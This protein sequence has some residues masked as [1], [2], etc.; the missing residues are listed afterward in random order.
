MD[1]YKL[2][3]EKLLSKLEKETL[4][5]QNKKLKDLEEIKKISKDIKDIE[6][7]IN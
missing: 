1:N 6:G 7:I 4:L 3:F 2:A 5:Q